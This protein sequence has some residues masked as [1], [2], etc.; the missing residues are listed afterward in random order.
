MTSEEIFSRVDHTLLKA[1]ASWAEI[2][3]LC[4]EAARY[5]TASVCVPPS[6]V[7]PI[8]EAFADVVICTVIGFPLGYNLTA[9]KA[10]E[11]KEAI[12]GGASEV[13]MV[14]NVG[15]VKNRN[16]DA[17]LAE[18]RTLR[19][20][21]GTHILKVIVETCYLD[22]DEKI[23]LCGLVSDAGADYIKTSTGFGQ[24]GAVLNDI[25]LFRKHLSPSVKIKASGGIRT[26][27]A[28]EAFITAGAD[29]IG[30]SS[31]VAVLVRE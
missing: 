25:L 17:V 28:M 5:K 2:D 20:A 16:F 19:E 21:A 18:I 13:D 30:S 11:A 6:Y 8:K 23:K 3:K 26:R 9:V 1:A 29:R 10:F 15:E 22:T 4:Y 14:I 12:A 31:A 27:E 24:A 7:K